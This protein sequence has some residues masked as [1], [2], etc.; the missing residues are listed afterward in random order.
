MKDYADKPYL[1]NQDYFE[2]P[3]GNIASLIIIVMAALY[4]LHGAMEYFGYFRLRY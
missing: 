4:F 1:K 2:F 3:K